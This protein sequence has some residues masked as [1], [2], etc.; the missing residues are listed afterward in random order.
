MRERK[1]LIFR[2]K[3]QMCIYLKWGR[4][5]GNENGR[6]HQTKLIQQIIISYLINYSSSVPLSQSL[7]LSSISL[8]SM[9]MSLWSLLCWQSQNSE[10][11]SPALTQ[12]H[13][14]LLH[15]VETHLQYVVCRISSGAIFIPFWSMVGLSDF[16]PSFLSQPYSHGFSWG[17]LPITQFPYMIATA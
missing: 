10:Q 2:T 14:F 3:N 15:W 16:S 5:I 4:G 11:M 7:F 13:L 8:S 6:H 17:G 1:D 9:C 12:L